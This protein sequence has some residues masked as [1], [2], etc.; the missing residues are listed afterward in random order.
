MIAR[1]LATYA[2]AL[3]VTGLIAATS[4]TSASAGQASQSQNA[5]ST[6]RAQLAENYGRLPLSFEANSGQADRS[7]KFLSRG[8]GYRLY[9]TG[10]EAVLTLRRNAAT[11]SGP[12][13][14]LRMQL[15]GAST[16]TR[17]LGEEQL[18]GVANYFIGS[19]P[20]G[21]HTNIPTFA[22]VRYA[23]VYPGIDLVYYGNQ[24]QLEY[25]FAVAPGAS[26]GV[27]RLELS[28]AKQLH[29]AANGDLVF[30]LGNGTLAFQ[31]PLVYQVV[32]GHRQPVAGTF[33]LLGKH[34]VGFRLGSYDRARPL[35][36]D[37]VLQ[38]TAVRFNLDLPPSSSS[39]CVVYD[40]FRVSTI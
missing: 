28:G 13:D 32:D 2:R 27:I 26:P 5:S 12:V 8:S 38:Y 19:D 24:R 30:M 17:P 22:K 25:D 39:D 31:K 4:F 20:A 35:V 3:F 6:H 36:I 18:P 33:A 10:N 37:P 40:D 7:V 34:T 16:V 15:A 23:G 29:V 11:S 1:F 9:L 14:Q 21:W